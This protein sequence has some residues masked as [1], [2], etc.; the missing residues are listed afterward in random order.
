MI[1]RYFADVPEELKDAI[2]VRCPLCDIVY[3]VIKL[4]IKKINEIIMLET[5]C[6]LHN[7]IVYGSLTDEIATRLKNVGIRL[8]DKKFLGSNAIGR[9]NK[10]N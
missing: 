4:K 8:D 7:G 10:T 3:K 1:Q 9:G 2:L 5:I 6:P